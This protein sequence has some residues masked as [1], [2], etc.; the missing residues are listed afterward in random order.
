MMEYFGPGGLSQAMEDE[1]H[2]NATS[3]ELNEAGIQWLKDHPSRSVPYSMTVGYW[4]CVLSNLA[5][6]GFRVVKK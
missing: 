3:E 4:N 2:T 1:P 6:W 5:A